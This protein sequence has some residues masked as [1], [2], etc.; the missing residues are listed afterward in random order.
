MASISIKSLPNEVLYRIIV[1]VE[2]SLENFKALTLTCH[3]FYDIM[4]AHAVLQD[5]A[6]TQYPHALQVLCYPV[7]PFCG[8]SNITSLSCLNKL[9]TRTVAAERYIKIYTPSF[10]LAVDKQVQLAKYLA[11]KGWEHTLRTGLHLTFC[12][13][14]GRVNKQDDFKALINWRSVFLRSIPPQHILA[15]S[16]ALLI[17]KKAHLIDEML[18]EPEETPKASLRERLKRRF[19]GLIA[20][21]HRP[22]AT[23]QSTATQVRYLRHADHEDDY[24][25]WNYPVGGQSG[26]VLDGTSH[27]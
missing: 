12:P 21:R 2:F 26:E 10:R 16:H 13:S 11:T 6:T 22:W 14:T 8:R 4:T 20:R 24:E 15:Y 19:S 18:Y 17:M 1:H 27:P 7:N 9:K 5:I 25:K 3:Q 23:N